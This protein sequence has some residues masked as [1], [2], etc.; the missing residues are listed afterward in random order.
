MTPGKLMGDEGAGSGT[1]ASI[2]AREARQVRFALAA[3]TARRKAML[4]LN[5]GVHLCRCM[6]P[7]ADIWGHWQPRLGRGWH[8]ASSRNESWR[9]CTAGRQPALSAC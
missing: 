8:M 7:L 3:Q 4:I 9:A 1:R 5:I 6:A 2:A